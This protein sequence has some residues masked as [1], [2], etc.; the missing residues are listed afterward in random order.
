MTT[1]TVWPY[2]PNVRIIC[3][4]GP[5]PSCE[6]C[7]EVRDPQS[8]NGWREIKRFNDMSNDFAHS[9]A[10]ACALAARRDLTDG[11]MP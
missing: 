5:P 1:G 9:E 2:G 11:V 6:L 10:T 8:F 3:R 7:V 4:A